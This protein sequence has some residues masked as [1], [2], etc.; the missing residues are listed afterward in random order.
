M[1]NGRI[2]I[3]QITFMYENKSL[4]ISN[5]SIKRLYFI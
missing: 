1:N 4:A 5:L 3:R 2:G